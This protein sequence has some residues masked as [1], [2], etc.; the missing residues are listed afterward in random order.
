MKVAEAQARIGTKFQFTALLFRLALKL[1]G[2]LL[3]LQ[4]IVLSSLFLG[5]LAWLGFLSQEV[6][7]LGF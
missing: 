3:Q 5:W 4:R 1:R 2:G 6:R 7:G